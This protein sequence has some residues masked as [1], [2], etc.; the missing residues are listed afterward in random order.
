MKNRPSDVTYCG[1]RESVI[2]AAN[3]KLNEEALGLYVHMIKERYK[4]RLRKDVR[5]EPAPWTDDPILKEYRFTNVRREHDRESIWFIKNIAE[6]VEVSYED[7][8]L[9]A[10]LFRA[11]NKSKTSE[12]IGM[13]LKFDNIDRE[14][15]RAKIQA[16]EKAHPEYVWF[17]SAFITG[18]LNRAAGCDVMVKAIGYDVDPFQDTP[19]FIDRWRVK[20]PAPPAFYL[21]ENEARRF[22]EECPDYELI[23]AK[24]MDMRMRMINFVEKIKQDGFI[25]KVAKA[26][27]QKE[28]F[29]LL[30]RYKGLADFLSYQIF[31]DFTYIPEFRFGENEF[32]ISGPGCKAGLDILFLNR[33]GMTHDEAVFWIR[34]NLERIADIN[35]YE[36]F[37][38]LEEHDRCA[39][40]MSLENT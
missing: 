15:I 18:G 2:A 29:T 11:F 13:P 26:K 9:N 20:Q 1:V 14:A 37:E 39:N 34:N 25:E 23:E 38:D 8:L 5:K 32:T 30:T 27:D 17:T 10:I 16:H 12:I 31:V 19:T 28:V 4:I 21:T 40:V 36:L 24:E 6:N 3:P 7:K 22:I 33:D 35:F